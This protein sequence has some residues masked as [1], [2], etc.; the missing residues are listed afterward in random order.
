MIIKKKAVTLVEVVIGVVLSAVL[1][2]VIMNLFSSGMKGSVK[3]LAHQANMET[4]SII[5]SQIEYDLLRGVSI[6]QPEA[7]LDEDFD[8]AIW[9]L[10]YIASGKREH[11][12]VTY[13]R[14]ENGIGVE[15][16]VKPSN[17]KPLK[18]IFAKDKKVDLKFKHLRA[19]VGT[20]DVP[21]YK[22]GM[23]V[24]LTVSSKD[25]KKVGVNSEESFTLS[26]LIMSRGHDRVK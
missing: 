8:K 23:L 13:T 14:L 20:Q 21:L 12:T 17:G 18:V 16:E 11:A 9:E 3:G 10:Y 15:R 5:M 4:A 1:I 25:S 26:R 2:V 6:S 22:H 7:N 19:N 24:K